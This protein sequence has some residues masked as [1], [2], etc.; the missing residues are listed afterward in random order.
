MKHWSQNAIFYHIYPMGFC[1]A[2][3]RNDF[4]SPAVPR[5][6]KISVWLDHIQGV[7]ANALYLGPL[8][9]SSAHG[10]DTVDYYWVDRR[11]GNNVLL[12]KLSQ[13]IHRRGMHLVLDGVFNHVGR[14]FWAFYDVRQKGQ[15]SE[16]ASWFAGLSFS[17]RSPFG[18]PFTY[19]GWNGHYELVKLNLANPAV[20]E[21]LFGAVA[22]WVREF[23]IDGLR[24]DAADCLD[25]DF[26]RALAGY[27]KRLRP[28]FWLLGEIIHG[29]Y[30]Q[31]ANPEMLDS[32]T[33]YECYKGLYSSHKDN[34]YF[35]LAYSLQ[36]QFGPSGMYAH[37]P[38]YAF[39]DNHDVDRVASSLLNP[40]QL[41][42]LYM[43]L[44]SMPGVPSIYY[45]SEWGILGKRTAHSD[46]E[47]RPDLD[48]AAMRQ[49]SPEPE[50]ANWISR[51]AQARMAC[52]M[53]QYGDYEQLFVSAQ[54]FAFLRRYEGESALVAVNSAGAAMRLEL[55]VPF[56]AG[57]QLRDLLQPQAVFTVQAGKVA[58]T[59]EA[60]R[61]RILVRL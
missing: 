39:A 10:Y 57:T 44:F 27:C 51:L 13:E 40:A 5:L 45:G 15:D 14:D 26:I 43:L 6:D 9:E 21:H 56:A 20:R 37:L 61:G 12:A 4:S 29:D 55:S 34:N 42:P 22:S 19:T 53:L 36:R 32:V 59:L 1:G 50:L 49:H 35:E 2:P 28:D 7:G 24:L 11:L 33:N 23:D 16:Y 48:L 47:L 31:W 52:P 17:G 46:R 60:C 3:Q 58:L 41:Y 18:D 30:R 25:F 38:L 54:Q 8:F